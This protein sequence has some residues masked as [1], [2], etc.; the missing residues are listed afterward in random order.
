MDKRA[1]QIGTVHR[2]SMPVTLAAKADQAGAVE[3]IVSAFDVDYRIGYFGK[4]RIE[5]GAFADTLAEQEAIPLF[6]EH[7]WTA[8]GLPIG[9]ATGSEEERGLKIAGQLYLDDPA[10]ARVHKAM[11]AGA[12]R[13][14]S[15]GYR[16]LEA[17]YPED[18]PELTIVTKAELLEASSVVRGANPQTE[19]IKVASAPSDLESLVDRL[20]AERVAE[21]LAAAAPNVEEKTGPEI[22]DDA[23]RLLA[24]AAFRAQVA[25]SLK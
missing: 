13:E 12:V 21:A 1:E 11:Q 3:A 5:A 4:H 22:L 17:R 19:T 7:D 2:A 18:Q 25:A 23:S 14:W 16:V 6:W 10:V 8:G 24:N 15:I 9:H 20:V